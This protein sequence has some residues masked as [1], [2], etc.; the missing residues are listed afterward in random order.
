VDL[1]NGDQP[2]GSPHG[3]PRSGRH[4]YTLLPQVHPSPQESGTRKAGTFCTISILHQFETRD[5]PSTLHPFLLNKFHPLSWDTLTTSPMPISCEHIP[6]FC[7]AE[8]VVDSCSI[9]QSRTSLTH[10]PHKYQNRT[11]Q[12]RIKRTQNSL[13]KFYSTPTIHLFPIPIPKILGPWTPTFA[14][15]VKSLPIQVSFLFPTS[16]LQ[17]SEW[18]VP[19]P[20]PFQRPFSS[21]SPSL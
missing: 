18:K 16:P 1:S 3:Q 7:T 10:R 15:I 4:V 5:P 9:L 17:D 19:I 20:L 8:H 11:Q 12:S 13:K 2:L 6:L 21:V 14:A